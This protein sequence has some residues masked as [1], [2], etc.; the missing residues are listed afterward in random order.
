M[1]GGAKSTKKGLSNQEM[2][3]QKFAIRPQEV[4]I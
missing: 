1:A 3:K 2:A 4:P